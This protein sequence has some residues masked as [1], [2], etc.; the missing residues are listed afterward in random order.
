MKSLTIIVKNGFINKYDFLT[1]YTCSIICPYSLMFPSV[2]MFLVQL[3]GIAKLLWQL[4]QETVFC[5]D[6]AQ[7]EI[8]PEIENKLNKK[9]FIPK[10]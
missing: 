10:L 1:S 7:P 5:G 4:P 9:A 8:T 3:S 6:L 2:Q